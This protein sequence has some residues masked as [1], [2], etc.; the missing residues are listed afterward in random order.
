MTTSRAL[1]VGVAIFPTMR[2]IHPA[3][4]AREAEEMGFDSLFFPEHTHIPVASQNTFL[5]G[6]HP[7]PEYYRETLDPFVALTA[8][9]TATSTLLLGTGICLITERDPIATAKAIATLDQLSGGRFVFGIGAG[10]NTYELENHGTDPSR[11]F[12]VM[13]ERVEAMQAIWSQDEASYHGKYVDFDRIWSWPKPLQ[14]PH[15]PI[16]IGGNGPKALDRV[17]AYGDGWLPEYEPNLFDRITELRQRAL[18]LGRQRIEI[19]VYS[20]RLDAV[21]DYL[22]V[23]ADRCVFWLPPDDRSAALNR[24]EELAS[25]FKLSRQAPG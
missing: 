7:V 18:E 22:R 19:T 8:A 4:L 1:R 3:E 10:W 5:G 11:R 12:A 16:L 6:N 20:A 23:G 14:R 15:P 2:G 17:L 9:A 24:L 25:A 13:R 21:G